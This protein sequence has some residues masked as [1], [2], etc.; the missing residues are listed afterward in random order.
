ML[1][2][3]MGLAM[4]ISANFG[5]YTTATVPGEY[6]EFVAPVQC[7]DNRSWTVAV[8]YKV[9]VDGKHKQHLQVRNL[10]GC[11]TT[12]AFIDE[13]VVDPYITVIGR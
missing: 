12:K 5:N 11:V 8:R 13:A 10:P 7:Q 9:D 3:F 4:L 6:Y 2:I 1:E